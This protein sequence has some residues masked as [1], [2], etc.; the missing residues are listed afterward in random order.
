MGYGGEDPGYRTIKSNDKGAFE[1]DFSEDCTKGETDVE[2]GNIPRI[3][4]FD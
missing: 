4:Y 2:F 1:V 3:L